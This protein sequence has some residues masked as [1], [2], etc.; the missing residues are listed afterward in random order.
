MKSLSKSVHLAG[1][2]FVLAATSA[3]AQVTNLFSFDEFG[4]GNLRTNGVISAQ[5]TYQLA[6]DPTGGLPNWNVLM[7]NLPFLGTAGDV[8]IQDPAQPGN[9]ILDVLRFDGAS[10]VI[11][12]SDNIDGYDAPG[13]T[14]GPPDPFLPNTI[15][16]KEQGVDG[17]FSWADYTPTAGQPGWDA[18]MTP[19]YYFLSDGM[20]PEPGGAVLLLSGLGVLGWSRIRR[21]FATRGEGSRR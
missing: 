9:P 14:P 4:K 10:H 17:V 8:L 1:L 5:M 19:N 12:Y 13:D 16:A 18:G 11:I 3:T 6:P 15:F 7:Y 2:A 20:I 21:W